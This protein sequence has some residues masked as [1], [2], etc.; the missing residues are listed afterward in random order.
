[1]SPSPREG[2]ARMRATI[3][4][5]A[6]SL[7]GPAAWTADARSRVK[8]R[9]SARDV[10]ARGDDLCAGSDFR[11]TR[12]TNIIATSHPPR[13]A[14]TSD[15][16]RPVEGGTIFFCGLERQCAEQLKYKADYNQNCGRQKPALAARLGGMTTVPGA[17]DSH[18]ILHFASACQVL[19]HC[20]AG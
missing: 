13:N 11:E 9:P 6:G 1:M 16:V 8:S 10:L 19:T 20:V 5:E 4:G 18:I 15:K 7:S 14:Y 17:P 3:F 2:T 12:S